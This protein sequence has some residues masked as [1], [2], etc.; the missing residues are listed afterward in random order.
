MK[1][2]ASAMTMTELQD[3][4]RRETKVIKRK[5]RLGRPALRVFRFLREN[6]MADEI[7]DLITNAS[8]TGLDT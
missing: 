5:I 2:E 4:R 3:C 1:Y 6:F 8:A 7:K